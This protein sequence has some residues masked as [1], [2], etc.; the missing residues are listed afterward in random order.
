MYAQ[1]NPHFTF[2]ALSSIQGLINNNDIKGANRYLSDFA[3]LVRRSLADSEQASIPC[4]RS[5]KL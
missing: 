3:S 2:N 1:L 5:C 4:S